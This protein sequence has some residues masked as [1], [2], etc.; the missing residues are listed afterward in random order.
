MKN[1]IRGALA[2]VIAVSCLTTIGIL[3]QRVDGVRDAREAARAQYQQK[4]QQVLN[5]KEGYAAAIVQRWEADAQASGKWDENYSAD[6]RNALMR[7][8]PD[9]LL[10]AGEAPTYED[11]LGVLKVGHLR[12]SG[13]VALTGQP[14]PRA[15]GD[16]A[17]DLV[18]TPISPCRIVD[19]RVAGGAIA[20]GT[21]R[22]FD[23]DGSTFVAQG[24]KNASCG[25]PLGV[26]QAVA[27]NI[28]VTQPAAAGYFTAWAVG[29]SQPLS[30][31]LNYAAGET[32]ANTTI[33][34]VVPGAGNDFNL[35]SASTAHAV[36]DVLGYFAAPV[37]T[38]LDCTTIT[39]ASTAVA[40][41]VWTPITASCPAGRT[42]TGGGY[43]TPEGTLGYPGVW[44]TTH[45]SGNGCAL[46]WGGRPRNRRPEVAR[47]GVPGASW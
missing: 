15:L 9:N 1:S 22:S 11:V 40:V 19:T 28:T 38:A 5:D 16:L 18:Y 45:A 3:A 17:D 33:V 26:A 39:S 23:V 13:N 27:M 44:V 31:I 24:G 46:S 10:A 35:F 21:T 4:L 12:E 43:D 14:L 36:I 37:A 41:N 2:R 7:L 25:I 30:S 20:G 6:L 42:A 34:P 47:T 29:G 8:P 32:V